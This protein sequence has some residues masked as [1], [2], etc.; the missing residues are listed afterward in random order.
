VSTATLNKRVQDFIVTHPHLFIDRQLVDA[1]SGQTIKTANPATE[2]TLAT[3][4]DDGVVDIDLAVHPARRA[5]DD[6]P[7]SR[8]TP[9]E[10]LRRAARSSTVGGS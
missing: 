5:F 7:W 8:M 9:S 10:R 4:A 2:E 6:G 1:K 3:I